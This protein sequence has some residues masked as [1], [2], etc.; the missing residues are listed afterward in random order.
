MYLIHI[1][2]EKWEVNDLWVYY[3]NSWLT[4]YIILMRSERQAGCRQ[5][6]SSWGDSVKVLTAISTSI[7][8]SWIRLMHT[9]WCIKSRVKWV[10]P[11]NMHR[12]ATGRPVAFECT[13]WQGSHTER[14]IEIIALIY[15]P[16][17]RK[18]L[19]HCVWCP[20]ADSVRRMHAIDKPSNSNKK[21][22][23]IYFLI[24][25]ESK[26]PLKL[27]TSRKWGKWICLHCND[28]IKMST[29]SS[30]HSYVTQ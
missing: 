21:L 11:K 2:K 6:E 24:I 27:C 26:T 22:L 15:L 23:N 30:V 7:K 28:N 1:R 19:L 18:K 17:R 16:H 13:L 10:G 14:I 4:I 12:S 5:R 8:I 9:Y 20:V 25:P 3:Y 29:L